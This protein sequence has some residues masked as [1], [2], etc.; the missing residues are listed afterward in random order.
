MSWSLLVRLAVDVE[1]IKFVRGA[2]E[3]EQRLSGT[4]DE[5]LLRWSYMPVQLFGEKEKGKNKGGKGDRDRPKGE[6]T[7]K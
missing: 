2:V 1:A 6:K 3:L 7:D 4:E 5:V